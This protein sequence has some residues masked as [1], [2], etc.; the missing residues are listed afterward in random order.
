MCKGRCCNRRIFLEN[1]MPTFLPGPRRSLIVTRGYFPVVSRRFCPS[2]SKM[3]LKSQSL[4][5]CSRIDILPPSALTACGQTSLVFRSTGS[6]LSRRVILQERCSS[7]V[8]VVALHPGVCR[9]MARGGIP[10]VSRLPVFFWC[11]FDCSASNCLSLC[12]LR[13]II[14]N[15]FRDLPR[16]CHYE[17]NHTPW[18]WY[19]S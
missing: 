4:P 5:S 17:L 12:R 8:M 16:D 2:K 11:V 10:L 14:L 7:G 13:P 6:L 15:I 3:Y 18:P 9:S 19:K 1:S